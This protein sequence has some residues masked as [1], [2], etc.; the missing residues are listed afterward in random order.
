MLNELK[1]PRML[2]IKET[3][4]QTNLSPYFIRQLV[5]QK[6]KNIRFIKVGRKY[7]INLNSL[8]EFLNNGDSEQTSENN[9]NN[10]G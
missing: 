3:A 8:V 4:K 7:L 5:L 10:V 1:L 9:E 2:T 6:N